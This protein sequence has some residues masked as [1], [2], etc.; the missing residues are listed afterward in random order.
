ME[1]TRPLSKRP[2]RQARSIG[3]RPITHP[4][5]ACNSSNPRD[6]DQCQGC[7]GLARRVMLDDLVV[8]RSACQGLCCLFILANR[9]VAPTSV[10]A[11]RDVL[12]ISSLSVEEVMGAAADL[13]TRWPTLSREEQR[14]IVDAVVDRITV[15]KDEI[16]IVLLVSNSL[17]ILSKGQRTLV[18]DCRPGRGGSSRFG[19]CRGSGS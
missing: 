15:G 18:S 13:H 12:R 7:R 8:R 4:I 1:L 14:S 2:P 11:S 5:R 17:E 3:F 10:E 9:A 16:A 6:R 19:P